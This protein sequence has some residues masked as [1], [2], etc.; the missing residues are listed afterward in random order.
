[1]KK[2]P[3]PSVCRSLTSLASISTCTFEV[4]LCWIKPN[5]SVCVVYPSIP[6][7]NPDKK[8]LLEAEVEKF[9]RREGK[10]MMFKCSSKSCEYI[11][12]IVYIPKYMCVLSLIP[13]LP[14]SEAQTLKLCGQGPRA[15][16]IFS[17]MSSTKGSMEVERFNCTHWRLRTAEETKTVTY[18]TYLASG[19]G[20]G[21]DILHTEH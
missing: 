10:T 11:L 14:R 15:R 19:W 8:T 4:F 7:I 5:W 2:S 3:R 18:L 21:G 6:Q 12:C 17:H 1:M 20:G 16:G 9:L 13:R